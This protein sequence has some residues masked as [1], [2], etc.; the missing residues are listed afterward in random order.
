MYQPSYYLPS[1]VTVNLGAEEKS[2]QLWNL[3]ID[4][5]KG[6][7]RQVHDWLFTA[8]SIKSITWVLVILYLSLCLQVCLQLLGFKV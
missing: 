1:Y 4:Q 8:S 5:M 7:C 2:V 3:C 6:T